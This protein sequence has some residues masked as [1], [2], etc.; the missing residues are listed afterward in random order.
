MGRHRRR[1]WA[2]AERKVGGIRSLPPAPAEAPAGADM[3]SALKRIA[4]SA[5]AVSQS[6]PA[7]GQ[8]VQG[9]QSAIVAYDDVAI[10][11]APGMQWLEA[12]REALANLGGGFAMQV[13]FDSTS[14]LRQQISIQ[15]SD[16][17]GSDDDVPSV[18]HDPASYWQRIYGT[19]P[20]PPDKYGADKY[21]AVP[22]PPPNDRV[23]HFQFAQRYLAARYGQGFAPWTVA[24][25]PDD[26]EA[27]GPPRSQMQEWAQTFDPRPQPLEL[28]DDGNPLLPSYVLEATEDGDPVRVN[29]LAGQEEGAQKRQEWEEK[30]RAK[31]AERLRA[32]AID[33]NAIVDVKDIDLKLGRHQAVDDVPLRFWRFSTPEPEETKS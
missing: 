11:F 31:Q 24:G 20:D 9:L 16:D 17:Q 32:K 1:D 33:L 27:V 30:A 23:T 25:S 8:S 29:A 7:L 12:I 19:F 26:Y 18:S 22:D 2:T 6:W 15:V 5:K 28:D 4:A 14:A 10:T 13:T 3:I 21:G